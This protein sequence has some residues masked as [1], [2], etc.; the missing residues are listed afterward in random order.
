MKSEFQK[1]LLH[2]IQVPKDIKHSLT[3]LSSAETAFE[4]TIQI[5]RDSHLQMERKN[6]IEDLNRA[7]N[8]ILNSEKVYI[9]GIGISR[10]VADYLTQRL[11]ILDIDAATVDVGDILDLS[12][13]LTA[14]TE[15]DCFVLMSFPHYSHQIRSFDDYLHDSKIPYVGGHIRQ[16]RNLHDADD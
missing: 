16:R 11:K 3:D 4:N 2:E 7:A 10:I 15:K 12:L 8:L 6:S 5:Q 14:S 1:L 9:A 13:T